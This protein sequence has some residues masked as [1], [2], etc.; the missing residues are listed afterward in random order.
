M[1]DDS[2]IRGRLHAAFRFVVD[3]DGKAQAAFTECDLPII[4]LNLQEVKEGG[5]N[6]YL[7][8]LPG[9]RKS[10]KVIL[11]HGIG[12]SDLV[13][14]FIKVMSEE[15]VRKPVTIILMNS[16]LEPQMT[17]NLDGAYPVKWT[18]PALRSDSSTVAIQTLELVC[19]EITVKGGG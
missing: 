6:T 5:L 7:H 3:I 13:D 9:Q 18:G 14:W 8:Q 10:A 19:N 4:D 15:F 2:V 16:T 1:A 17:W 12:K 11:K